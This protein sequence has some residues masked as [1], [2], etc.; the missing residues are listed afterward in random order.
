MVTLRDILTEEEYA[1]AEEFSPVYQRIMKLE[2]AMSLGF[3]NCFGVVP[4][5]L[6]FEREVFDYW[7]R[8]CLTQRVRER[9]LDWDYVKFPYI[10]NPGYIGPLPMELFLTESGVVRE[11][12]VEE[13]SV[14]AFFDELDKGDNEGGKGQIIHAGVY[15][16]EIHGEEYMFHQNGCGCKFEL[17]Q[18]QGYVGKLAFME[19]FRRYVKTV[20]NP[21]VRFYRVGNN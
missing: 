15:L 1:R 5:V 13:A 2:R 6:E 19:G 9:K 8:V 17:A 18:V 16:G 4:H 21:I 11:S 3:S 7:K 12:G 20:E 14:V 10:G